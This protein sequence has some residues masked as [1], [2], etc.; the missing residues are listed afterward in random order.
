MA[1][2]S[3]ATT[4]DL[5]NEQW[6]AQLYK[7]AQEK[8]FFGKFKGAGQG[9]VVQVKRQLEKKAGDAITFGLSDSIRGTAGVTGNTPLEGH[10]GTSYTVNNEAMVFHDQRVVIDQIRQSIKLSGIMD[11]KRV[12]FN[13]RNEARDKLVDWMSWNEDQAL[14]TALNTADEIG[15]TGSTLDT[16]F[17]TTHSTLTYDAI[18]D[19]KKE[20]LYPTT[21][22][23]TGGASTTRRLDAVR[24]NG[25]EEL[26]VLG[27]NPAD[28]AAFRKSDDFKNF[29]QNAD[30]RGDS[31]A[32]FTGMLG[33]FNNVVI[34]EHSGFV[35]GS[36]VLMGANALFLAYG[37]EIM[38]GED[39][40]DYDNQTGFMIGTIRGTALANFANE[41]GDAQGSN[42]AIKF[43][44]Y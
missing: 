40:F 31:N 25:G 8:T 35:A 18:V 4:H 13:L 17:G 12:A 6:E 30:V 14:F 41:A 1:M 10:N 34:H 29:N 3:I 39:T 21:N 43:K 22:N 20:A 42:G 38:Y 28:A 2:T 16:L 37:K 36:P 24:M 32:I 27:V 15:G 7:K 19:M 11:E 5:T 33:M 44:L 26:F 23:V 9:S